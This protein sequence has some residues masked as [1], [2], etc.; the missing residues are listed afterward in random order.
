M[1]R[2]CSATAYW[3]S[4]AFH[5]LQTCS[6][7]HCQGRPAKTSSHSSLRLRLIP[8][9]QSSSARPTPPSACHRDSVR[10]PVPSSCHHPGARNG[11]GCDSLRSVPRENPDRCHVSIPTRSEE[12]TSE[13]QTL[14]H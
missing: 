7:P 5:P 12:H 8:A 13:L 2:R 9:P 6:T 11:S 14:R 3:Y 1:A 10:I 4:K